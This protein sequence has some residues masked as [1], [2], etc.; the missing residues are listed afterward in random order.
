[1]N[2]IICGE[3]IYNNNNYKFDFRDDILII[4]PPEL[5]EYTK[6]SFNQIGKSNKNEVISLEGLT[7]DGW[8]ICFIDIKLY[9]IGRGALQ[10]FVPGYVICK[11]N[12]IFPVPKCKDIKSIR[13]YGECIDK[14]YNP[15]KIIKTSD[16]LNSESIKFEIDKSKL[17]TTN[18]IINGDSYCFGA[19]WQAPV[20]KDINNVLNVKSYLEIKFD[21]NKGVNEIIDYYLNVKKFFSFISNRKYVIFDNVVAYRTDEVDY[22][23]DDNHDVRK[24]NIEFKFEFVNPDEEIDLRDARLSVKL[25]QLGN[26]FVTLY[27]NVIE[28]GFITEYYP[29]SKRDDSFVDNNKFIN[30][31]RVFESEFDKMFKDFKSETSI[32]YKEVKKSILD[33]LDI[34]IAEI[35]DSKIISDKKSLKKKYKYFYN[36]IKKME[37]GLQEKV[38]YAIKSYSNIL[39]SKKQLL[40]NNYDIK[41]FNDSELA[42]IFTKRRNDIAHGNELEKFNSKEIIAYE[43][44]RICIYCVTLER[45]KYSQEEI[46]TIVN[47]LF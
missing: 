31:A 12:G 45:C 26:N 30:V 32:E 4:M 36:S 10:A 5:Q 44:V 14:L 27:K 33:L 16:L 8:Y 47:I 13:M 17:E 38:Y 41:Q 24:T 34:K 39:K 40:M 35:N 28:K 7:N 2:K 43:L 20:S 22:G 9:E 19:E 3:L 18:Y 23:F 21:N 42:E 46:E 1:M 29:L 15:K 6:W 11:A 25:D 37:G